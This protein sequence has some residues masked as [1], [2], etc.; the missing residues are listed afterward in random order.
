MCCFT[1]CLDWLF[2][3]KP[4]E[5]DSEM[6]QIEE[7]CH[8]SVSGKTTT[9]SSAW[10]ENEMSGALPGFNYED[11]GL[12]HPSTPGLPLKS[13]MASYPASKRASVHSVSFAVPSSLFAT[14]L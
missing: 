11:G 9:N 4:V 14:S 13:A 3:P 5:I 8:M 2:G 1:F 7:E 10:M 6:G 12:Q